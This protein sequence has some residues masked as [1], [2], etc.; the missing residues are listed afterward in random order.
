MTD[1]TPLRIGMMGGSFD[2]PHKAHYNVALSA[3]QSLRL[4]ALHMVPT[5]HAWHK[6]RELTAPTHR[7]AMAELAF[8]G[9]DGAIIDTCEIAREGAS[10]TVDTLNALQQSYTR[11]PIAPELVLV[12]GWDQLMRFTSWHQW[13]NIASRVLLAVAHRAESVGDAPAPDDLGQWQA[14]GL[15]VQ[16]L[17]VSP[18]TM[19]STAIRAQVAQ[20]P[21]ATGWRE[22]VAPE[23][24]DYIE[25]HGLYRAPTVA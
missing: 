12:V 20:Q 10:Y 5:G 24:A 6:A 18:V 14:L 7:V 11:G 22:Q 2:P 8:G 17:P 3:I 19:S 15:Q 13:Q 4:H 25:R 16:L 23:V 21:S 9:I 1:A